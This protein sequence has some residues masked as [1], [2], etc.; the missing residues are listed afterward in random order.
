[1]TKVSKIN[2]ISLVLGV[3][4]IVILASI[5]PESCAGPEELRQAGLLKKLA[6]ETAAYPGAK[7]TDDRL[8]YKTNLVFYFTH[9]KTN[10]QFEKVAEFYHQ[11]LT[12][13]GWKK[14]ETDPPDQNVYRKG[15]YHISIHQVDNQRYD[16]QLTFKWTW[17]EH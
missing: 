16:V 9:W 8:T 7:Q 5:N 1:M 11:Q 6:T 10:A 4:G 2:L 12:A 15:D 3:I 13:K 17:P 14:Q